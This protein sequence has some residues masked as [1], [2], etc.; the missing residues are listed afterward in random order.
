[1]AEAAMLSS[2]RAEGDWIGWKEARIFQFQPYGR[3]ME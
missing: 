3:N 1:M 2:V